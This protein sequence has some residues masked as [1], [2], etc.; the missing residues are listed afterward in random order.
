MPICFA[1]GMRAG[2][3]VALVAIALSPLLGEVSASIRVPECPPTPTAVATIAPAAPQSPAFSPGPAQPLTVPAAPPD[4]GPNQLPVATPEAAPAAGPPAAPPSH[5]READD[6][7]YAIRNPAPA[8]QPLRA[9]VPRAAIQRLPGGSPSNCGSPAPLASGVGPAWTSIGP[10]PTNAGQIPGGGPVAGRVYAVVPDPTDSTGNTIYVGAAMGGV[11][12]TVNKG[13]TWTPLTDMQ[14]SLA[15]TAIVLDPT[16]TQHVYAATG[17][18]TQS[19]HGY[20]SPSYFGAGILSSSDGGSSWSTV[21]AS[22]LTGQAIYDMDISPAGTTLYVAASGGFYVGTLSGGAWTFVWKA[23]GRWTSVRVNPGNPDFV[24]L[25]GLFGHSDCPPLGCGGIWRYQA[26]TGAF[27]ASSLGGSVGPFQSVGRTTIAV[28]KLSPTFVYASMERCPSNDCSWDEAQNTAAWWG[29][30]GS[31]DSG[32]TFQQLVLQDAGA[33]YGQ[34]WYDLSLAVDPLDDSYVYFGL[35]N[36]WSYNRLTGVVKNL[37]SPD[38][39]SPKCNSWNAGRFTLSPGIHCDQHAFGFDSAGT[40][41]VGNDGGVFSSPP[42]SHGS[43]WSDLNGNLTIGQFYPGLAY[44]TNNPSRLLVG[45]Q[46]N[47]SQTANGT[48]WQVTAP[49]DGGYNAIDAADP[50]NTWYSS[51]VGLQISKTLNGSTPWTAS[52]G[53]MWDPATT[54]MTHDSKGNVQGALF[55]A[56][57]TMDPTNSQNLLAGADR[58]YLTRNGA[59]SWQDISGAGAQVDPPISATTICPDVSN[60]G[61]FY[62]GTSG[63][64]VF[65]TTNGYSGLPNPSWAD[66]TANLPGQWVTR[67]VCDPINGAV[68]ATLGGSGTNSPH[69]FKRTATATS[70]T[71][72]GGLPDTTVTSLALDQRTTPPTLYVSTDLG[73]YQS[74]DG[75]AWVL[76]GTGFPSVAVTDI[77]LD[78]A[79]SVM[80]AATHGRGVWRIAVN[81]PLPTPT[82]T[83]GSAQPT[84][85][86][87]SAQPTPTPDSAQP[88]P[89]P[90]SSQPTPTV[91]STATPTATL[92]PTRTSTA[93]ATQTAT[94]TPTMTATATQT[95]TPTPTFTATPTTTPGN[96]VLRLEPNPAPAALNGAPVDVRIMVDASTR[97]LDGVQVRLTYDPT[98]LAL[99]DAD[100]SVSGVQLVPGT[101]LQQTLV[102][103]VDTTTGTIDFAAGRSASQTPPSGTLLLATMKVRGLMEGTWPLTFLP[104]SSE[105]SFLGVDLPLT[106]ANG[107]VQVTPRSLAFSTQPIRGAAGFV[108][109]FQPVIAVR[110]AAGNVVLSDNSTAITLALGGGAGA[111]LI[112]NE[113]VGG[114]TSLMVTNGVSTFGGCKVD[115]SGADYMLLASA[116]GATSAST[117]P[118][119]ITLAGDTSGDCRVSI[120]DFSLVVTHFGKTASSPDWTDPIKL[121]YR[122]DLNGD[123]RVSVLDFSIVVS[124]FGSSA[125]TCAPASN[126]T[127]NP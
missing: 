98:K 30:W 63:G 97:Q 52:G 42:G 110:D 7:F 103:A 70:W 86:P 12:K 94:P 75:A 79:R 85:T 105:A 114:A 40:L 15:V 78:T 90:N 16:N 33:E 11:W 57:F 32:T 73:V 10:S 76:Y 126:G 64:R 17:D 116:S 109:G 37:A 74:T 95:F 35:V 13:T 71:S 117:A 46:D 49:G 66:V 61:V 115:A 34:A 56:P 47:G 93:T 99:I 23:I 50:T 38:L 111:T 51:Y 100:G 4:T 107:A 108:L 3:A 31:S 53:P 60:H 58:P 9:P 81:E 6:Y 48:Q 25:G 123:G 84:P 65:K 106:T 54:G 67:I 88:T 112:C 18:F 122:A 101:A 26:S 8:G 44:N 87:G 29:L 118:F 80:F 43:V 41:Y 96:V 24:H 68:Y 119:N 1:R 121:A 72:I 21:G 22:V 62:L 45:N 2:V 125:A 27:T 104:A 14:A 92:T 5:K 127:A 124:R 91:T 113:T 83:P 55:I 59:S 39:T 102:N 36:L 77:V 19:N 28:D 69:V 120:I 20:G 82:A 89:T